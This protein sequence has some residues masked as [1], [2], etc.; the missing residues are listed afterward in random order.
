MDKSVF[1]MQ[2]D[3]MMKTWGDNHYKPE[4][5]SLF[6][7]SFHSVANEWFESAIDYLIGNHRSAPMVEEI[8][9]AIDQAKNRHYSE[10]SDRGMEDII[11]NAETNSMADRDLVQQC[12]QVRK[13]YLTGKLTKDQFLKYCD[14]LE[15]LAKHIAQAKRMPESPRER[16][17]A[18]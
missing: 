13:D 11:S 9:K 16:Q 1:L 14:E 6:W 5:V 4:R 8:A 10:R 15:S 2:I 18:S 12:N 7:R 17:F 3:R